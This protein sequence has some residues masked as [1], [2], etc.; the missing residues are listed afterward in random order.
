MGFR[1]SVALCTYNG[2]KFIEEQIESILNQTRSVDQ[3]IICDDC[4]TDKT[5]EVAERILSTSSVDFSV[6]RN[7]VNLGFIKNFEKSVSLCTGD[8]IFLCDQDDVWVPH[9]VETILCAFKG[10]ETIELV[11]SDAYLTDEELNILDSNLWSFYGFKYN[12]YNASTFYKKILKRNVVTGATVAFKKSLL[13]RVTPFCESWAHDH[14]IAMLTSL[15][16][17]ILPINNSV[18]A[19]L[20]IATSFKIKESFFT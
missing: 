17:S 15:T 13:P 4:S 3:I 10:N 5:V 9:K 2:E 20:L 7:E 1:T 18:H 11:F 8:I 14:W 16:N 12:K 19:S 6:I